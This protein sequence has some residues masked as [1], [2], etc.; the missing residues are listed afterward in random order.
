MVL[1]L[2]DGR[3]SG[4]CGGEFSIGARLRGRCCSCILNTEAGSDKLCSRSLWLSNS[5][6]HFRLL[7]A[8]H[9]SSRRRAP[10]LP[11]LVGTSRENQTSDLRANLES[12]LGSNYAIERELGGGGMS[13][14]Y[15]AI[16]KSLGREVVIKILMPEL[17]VTLNIERFTR[18]IKLV[19]RL[20]Q[21]NIVP[22]LTAGAVG[23]LPYYSMPFIDGLTLR[24][25]MKNGPPPLNESVRILG[26]IARALD[27]AHEHGV[28]H[29]DIKPENVLL[30]G[31]TAV[32]TDF[33]IAKAIN[34]AKTQP[35][36][37][38]LTSAGTSLG[39][40]GYMAPEQASGD[41]VDARADIYAWGIVAYELIAGAHP[42]A[43]KRT[44]Q[45][46]IAAQIAEKP[47]PIGEVRADVPDALASLIMRAIE[48][49]PGARPQSARELLGM[50]EDSASA[51]TS[52]RTWMVAPAAVAILLVLAFL[53]R[54][55][56][57]NSLDSAS[58]AAAAPAKISTLAVLPFANNSGNSQDEYFSDGMTDELAR[59]LS[60]VP[61]LRIASHTSSYAFKGKAVPAQQIGRALNVGGLL[62]GT[63]RRSGNRLRVTAQ[64]TDAKSGLVVWTDGFERP[65]ADVFQVQDELTKA[66]V[67]ELT[68]AL[69]GNRAGSVAAESRGTT[70]PEAYDLYLRGRF[71][72]NKRDLNSVLEGIRDFES[73]I[74]RDSSF[75]RAYAALAS[76]YVILP[77]EGGYGRYP[78]RQ[79]LAQIRSV[80]SRALALDSTLAEPHAALALALGNNWLWTQAQQE[81]L[82][83]IALGPNY[84]TAH[85]WYAF[86][87]QDAGRPQEALAEIAR[88]RA[89]DPLSQIIADNYC[90]RTAIAGK[91]ELGAQA[92]REAR[93]ANLFDGNALS[94]MFRGQFDSAAADWKRARL[95]RSADGLAA[96]SIARAGHRAE[97]T[98]LLKELEQKGDKEPLNVALVYLGLGDK[99]NAFKWLDRAVD[100]HED[101]LFDY[102]TPVSGAILDPLRGDARFQRIIDRMG[103]TE[104]ARAARA[105]R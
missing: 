53:F 79:N 52:R 4:R 99:D 76:S 37:P 45:Q 67:T 63:V 98:A 5:Y 39:T 102:V 35:L 28:V 82:R 70:N 15:V 50:L 60:R 23:A 2:W 33:G 55:K 56:I 94:E 62:E 9:S 48:K 59:A 54:D 36:G 71:E 101:S 104:Y 19:A 20:Q 8:R 81:F 58:G 27:Y 30:S 86:W 57:G 25:H 74:A 100:R 105:G 97:A 80:V 64:L 87:L 26:D 77:Q 103:L 85:Q 83:A 29:R 12:A 51:G 84:P 14:V 65:A 95:I 96:Y 46:L 6:S 73:A 38:T 7:A 93:D 42:F 10:F 88:A 43:G 75:A 24:E 18:E 90:E 31:G 69:S 78:M 16:D 13:L 44:A 89:L 72:W 92:C 34:A 22:V 32:V 21:A 40:P 91:Q 3:F 11:T 1:V 68:P 49:D 47:R 17:A 41:K 61:S 66:I